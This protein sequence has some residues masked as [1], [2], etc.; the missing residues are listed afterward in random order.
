MSARAVPLILLLPL[1]ACSGADTRTG[2]SA[3]AQCIHRLYD[4]PLRQMP[5]QAAA[6]SC[7]PNRPLDLT[8]DAYFQQLATSL[9]VPFVAKD[10]GRPITLTGSRLATPSDQL[11]PPTLQLR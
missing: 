11:P 6:G 10:K 7:A 1:A 2:V 5:F 8:G 3:D 4:Y 9:N